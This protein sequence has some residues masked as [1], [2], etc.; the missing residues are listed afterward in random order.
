MKFFDEAIIKVQ[1]GKGG[2]GCVAFRRLKFMPFGGPNG[3][4]GGDGGSVYLIADANLNT[5]AD[6]RN[7]RQYKAGDG[8]R[9]MG[10]E[11]TGASADDLLILVPVGTIARDAETQEIIGDLTKPNQKLLVAQGGFHGLGNTRFKSSVNR[12]PRQFTKGSEGDA[13]TLHLELKVV[14]DV[15][16][17][18][19][20]NAGKS[21]LIRAISAARPK[22]ADY[23]FTTLHPNL[24]VVSVDTHRSFVV[25]DIPGLIEGASEGLGLGFQFLKHLTRTH[26]LL[27]LVDIAPMDGSDPADNARKIITELENYSTELATKDRWL[28][29]NKADLLSA[30][31]TEAQ[32][33]KVKKALKWK[34]ETFTI[35]AIKAQG[36]KDLCFKIMEYVEAQRARL[37]D[38]DTNQQASK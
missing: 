9:G 6:F 13:R 16:L 30:E 14:A 23:P 2:D 1:A 12:A 37:P 15:G 35:S 31:E 5:L 36:T 20:P 17:L 3:G 7:T 29:F 26:L 32:I 27:H 22:V 8:K 24:G 25:A 38:K 4:D 33:K 10:S 21:T 34:G 28:I 19:M 11:C 18:G